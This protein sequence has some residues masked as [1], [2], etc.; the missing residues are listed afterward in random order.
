MRSS[1]TVGGGTVVGRTVVVARG[2]VVEGVGCGG[3]VVFPRAGAVVAVVPCGVV[4]VVGVAPEGLFR[5]AV[6]PATSAAPVGDVPPEP[7]SDPD[8]ESEPGVASAVVDAA[9]SEGAAVSGVL[10]RGRLPSRPT[11]LTT[12]TSS[13]PSPLESAI[14]E[15]CAHAV[16]PS[17]ATAARAANALAPRR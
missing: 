14:V 7:S 11:L 6:A 8:P 13:S 1:G 15:L 17:S 10:E 16:V 12:K 3:T 5:D 9:A 4:G 2:L